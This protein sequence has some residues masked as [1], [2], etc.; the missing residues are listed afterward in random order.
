MDL[1]Y[2][3][4]LLGLTVILSII[5]MLGIRMPDEPRWASDGL[6]T[7]AWCVAIAGL[8]A[9]GT[10]FGVKFVVNMN[11]QALG[12]KQVAL[13]AATLAACYLIV[14]LMAPRRRLAKYA[15]ERARRSGVS[16]SYPENVVALA[17]PV[18][19]NRSPSE[20]TLTKAA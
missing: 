9:Y 3:V 5:F 20:P 18:G 7:D 4:A 19:E 10:A 13:A 11:E 8:I 17:L 16:E 15:A 1:V 12:L 2:S 6:T 14:R